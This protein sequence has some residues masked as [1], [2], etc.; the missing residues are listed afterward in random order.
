MHDYPDHVRVLRRLSLEALRGFE[1]A[2]RSMSFTDAADELGLTQSAVSKQ[3]RSIEDALGR[4]L[5]V[6]SARGLQL[7]DQA[8]DLLRATQNALDGL[9]AAIERMLGAPM[10][11]VRVTTW[12]SFASFWLTPRLERF[13]SEH[14]DVEI[15]VD[16]SPGTLPLDH[17]GFDLAL[18]L[19]RPPLPDSTHRWLGTEEVHLVAAPSVA[20]RI[21]RAKDLCAHTLLAFRDPEQRYP[22]MSWSRWCE[23]L[24][25]APGSHFRTIQFTSHEMTIRAALGGSGVAIGRTPAVLQHLIRGD[26]EPVLPQHLVGGLAYCLVTSATKEPSSHALAFM[27]WLVHEIDAD[28]RRWHEMSRAPRA[29]GGGL[30]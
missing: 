11:S 14:P 29:R 30:G 4:D 3:V 21:R 27:S 1:A 19:V 22:W 2:A 5:F 25:I 23:R 7:T 28:T 9:G 16:G 17:A 18:R 8:A 24:G 12:P 20:R 15:T 10:R 26:L 13:T 6:R